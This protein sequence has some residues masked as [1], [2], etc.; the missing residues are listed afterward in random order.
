MN[1]SPCLPI[2]VPS[3]H[4]E[5]LSWEGSPSSEAQVKSLAGVGIRYYE[6]FLIS[7]FPDPKA[8]EPLGQK[9]IAFPV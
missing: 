7:W 1:A 5:A 9:R 2:A 6:S 8:G 4:A 3:R